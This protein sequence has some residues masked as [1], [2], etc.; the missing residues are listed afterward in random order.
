MS[1]LHYLF[2]V[3]IVLSFE[4]VAAGSVRRRAR[5]H[6]AKEFF[7]DYM[8]DNELGIIANAH[9]A[10]ADE[11]SLLANDPRCLRLAE[12]HGVAVDFAKTGVGAALPEELAVRKYPDFMEKGGLYTRRSTSVLGSLY[13]DAK[14]KLAEFDAGDASAGSG[15]GSESGY[16]EVFLDED[17]VVDGHATYLAAMLSRKRSYDAECQLLMARYAVATE[18]ELLTLSRKRPVAAAAVAAEGDGSQR[19][20][21][22]LDS[23]GVYESLMRA[24]HLMEKA[25]LSRVVRAELTAC[26]QNTVRCSTTLSGLLAATSSSSSSSRCRVSPPRVPNREPDRIGKTTTTALLVARRHVRKSSGVFVRR[27]ASCCWVTTTTTL[28]SWP[29]HRRATS[30]PTTRNSAT[31]CWGLPG[32]TRMFCP[33]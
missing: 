2:F 21:V 14:Q 25:D 30:R 4:N 1:C 3:V 33:T 13:R 31:G 19:D 26:E 23:I 12:L 27:D 32:S 20:V 22:R 11:S 6:R 24:Q 16:G 9:V 8:Q 10:H 5:R 17:L 29:V 28:E 15:G 18:S 7:V